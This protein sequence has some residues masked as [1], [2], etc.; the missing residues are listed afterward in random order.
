MTLYVSRENVHIRS[1]AFRAAEGL[2]TYAE[3]AAQHADAKDAAASL[4]SIEA[5]LPAWKNDA[6]IDA[7]SDRVS[8]AT[9]PYKGSK[10][11][12]NNIGGSAWASPGKEIAWTFTPEESGCMKSVCGSVRTIPVASMPHVR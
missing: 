12:L 8:P 4:P 10:I 1:I 7:A 3:Y 5:E 9:T 11:S 2:P 6:T